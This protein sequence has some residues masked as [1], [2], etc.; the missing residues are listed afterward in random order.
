MPG[1][2]AIWVPEKEH[3]DDGAGRFLARGFGA[4][5]AIGRAVVTELLHAGVDVR[6]VSRGGQAPE[7][8]Q[9]VAADAADPAHDRD[10]FGAAQ[11]RT[12]AGG[13]PYSGALVTASEIRSTSCQ[14]PHRG[15]SHPRLGGSRGTALGRHAPAGGGPA[16][17]LGERVLDLPGEAGFVPRA[18]PLGLPI[19]PL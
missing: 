4:T 12:V 3:H 13:S 10:R 9:G 15:G 11:I 16:R 8:A 19:A 5:G 1:A 6:A 7:G 17:G 18:G 14:G 2:R